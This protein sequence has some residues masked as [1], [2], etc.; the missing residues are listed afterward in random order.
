MKNALG[1]SEVSKGV[2]ILSF[3]RHILSQTAWLS[4]IRSIA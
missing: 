4:R 2:A 1:S 3:I